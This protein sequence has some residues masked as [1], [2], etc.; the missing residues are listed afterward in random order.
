MKRFAAVFLILLTLC[1]CKNNSAIDKAVQM[2]ESILQAKGCKFESQITAD[3]GDKLY[4]FTMNCEADATGRVNFSVIEPESISG[5]SGHIT[6]EGGNL[7]FDDEVLAF[8]MIADGQVTPVSAPWLFIRTLR[9]GYIKGCATTD[10]GMHIQI[11]DSYKEDAMHVDIYTDKN[12][13]PIRAEFLW[14]GKRILSM[15]IEKFAFV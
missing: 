4:T 5:I 7:T 8:E 2:R 9:S 3:Y 12:E 13:T 6:A 15:D 14:R 1:G 10:E 11:D